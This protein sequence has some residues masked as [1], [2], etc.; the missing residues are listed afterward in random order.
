MLLKAFQE[1]ETALAALS[2]LERQAQYQRQAVD[3]ASRT[4]T[5][6]S[7]RFQQGLNSQLDVLIAQR[8]LIA[9]QAIAVQID[10]ERL[11]TTVSLI[12][13]LG[14]GWQARAVPEGSRSM[15]APPLK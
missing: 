8:A 7:Q 15:W 10:N 14:G 12:K 4:A 1:V 13:A 6:A 3:S 5:L 11:S 9:S 2:L